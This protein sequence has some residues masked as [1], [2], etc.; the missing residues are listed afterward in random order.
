MHAP[1]LNQHLRLQEGIEHL[2][3]QQLVAQL[4]VEAFHVAV[5]P[6]AARLDKGCLGTN[7]VDP[8]LHGRG[9]ELRSVVRADVARR[10][11]GDEQIGQHV[12]DIG[13]A[14]PSP[15]PDRQAL[16]GELVH[17]IQHPDL[18]PVPGTVLDEV[19]GPNVVRPLRPQPHAGAVVQ[20]QPPALGLPRRHTQP[21][22]APN[23]LHALV[24]AAPALSPEQR[25]DP[26]V[27]VSAI[28]PGQRCDVR[29]QRHLVV[30]FP[31]HLALRRTSRG[32]FLQHQL[33]QRQVSHRPPQAA[34]L[35]LQN[36]QPL[37][38]VQLQ[39]TKLRTPAVVG[40]LRHPDCP[41][42][43][44]HWLALPDQHLNLTQLRDDLLR[45]VMLARHPSPLPFA[46]GLS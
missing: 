4:A 16:A 39:P 9:H 14:Q 18:A 10:A 2:G 37:H 22:A 30:G 38:L 12:D 5:L 3:V 1:L 40:R 41:H 21:L 7:A 28:L 27:T 6:R 44:G 33:L 42:R 43:I 24:V 29:S 20:P 26:A 31:R 19:I 45:L 17:N 25:R 34:V 46:P 15:N 13:R 36:L 11:A 35:L 32:S 23:P 8:A